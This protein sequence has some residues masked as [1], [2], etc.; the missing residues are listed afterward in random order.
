MGF[1]CSRH[2]AVHVCVQHR[3]DV[4]VPSNVRCFQHAL[5][6]LSPEE[7][8]FSSHQKT[9]FEGG[10]FPPARFMVPCRRGRPGGL[11]RGGDPGSPANPT[12]ETPEPQAE[13]HANFVIIYY[14]MILW[15]TVS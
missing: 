1:S 6:A 2:R 8:N 7:P 11:G 15:Y 9:D 12:R 5:S 10:A 3:A 13:L 4:A 14:V